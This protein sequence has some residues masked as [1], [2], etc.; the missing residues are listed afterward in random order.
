M[1]PPGPGLVTGM[2]AA[3]SG[4]VPIP[5]GYTYLGV[6]SLDYVDATNH[7]LTLKFRLLRKQ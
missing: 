1:G 6:S 4:D 3:I 2:Y 7:K 5:S